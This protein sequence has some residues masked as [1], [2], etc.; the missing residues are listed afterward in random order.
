[1]KFDMLCDIV[2]EG[3][4]Q[5]KFARMV[6]GNTSPVFT[7]DD[8]LRDPSDPSKGLYTYLSHRDAK[9]MK[10]VDYE[11]LA[12]RAVRRF[13][14]VA[15]SAIKR[16]GSR[17]ISIT[18]LNEFIISLLEKYQ[19]KVLGYDHPDKMK[20]AQEAR[21]LGNLMLPPTK[22]RP[23]AKGV[24]VPVGFT[25]GATA[26]G[27][28]R[29]TVDVETVVKDFNA[30]AD[31]YIT[32]FDPDLIDTIKDIVAGIGVS[33]A[34]DG[35]Y[36][37]DELDASEDEFNNKEIAQESF[38]GEADGVSI[39]QILKDPRIKGIYDPRIV[40]KVIKSM[41]DIG[42]LLT[43]PEGNLALPEEGTEGWRAGYEKMKDRAA[44]IE[45]IPQENDIEELAQSLDNEE[46]SNA[47]L[48]SIEDEEE[49]V[50][51]A[52]EW[53]DEDAASRLGYKKPVSEPDQVEAE[54]EPEEEE[55]WFK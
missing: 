25:A 4:K 14:W 20:T 19:I 47:D 46:P 6:I 41:I 53:G 50:A 32:M 43:T 7:T 2:L 39:S 17:E 36:E 26:P 3:S 52:P 5:D 45:D 29:S 31:D 21:M 42:S 48:D 23:N 51:H 54:E 1:M 16:L 13:N 55:P 12:R 35:A 22:W 28:V 49:E 40:R 44:N 8:V 24:F 34:V 37:D 18:K 38:E 9:S 15:K 33:A 10:E 27:K 30:S 11:R